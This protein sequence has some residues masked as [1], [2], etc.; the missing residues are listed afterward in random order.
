FPSPPAR[1]KR[2]TW[3]VVLRTNYAETDQNFLSASWRRAA[4]QREIQY[5][6]RTGNRQFPG[7]PGLVH[8]FTSFVKIRAIRGFVRLFFQQHLNASSIHLHAAR[9]VFGY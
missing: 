4:K 3:N 6:I 8:C 7:S 2:T 5:G 1:D 9:A